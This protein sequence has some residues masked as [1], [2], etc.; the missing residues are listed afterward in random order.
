MFLRNF[1]FLKWLQNPY[2]LFS[3]GDCVELVFFLRCF[4][5]FASETIWVLFLSEGS[6]L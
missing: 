2:L 6:K 5:E 3:G 1:G 4:I